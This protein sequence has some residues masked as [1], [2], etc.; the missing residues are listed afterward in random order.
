MSSKPCVFLLP[1]LMCDEA[2]WQQ[3]AQALAP[4]ADIRIPVFRGYY[5]LQAMAEFVL[6]QAPEKFSLAGHSMGGRVAWEVMALAG[7]RIERL[8]VLD[9]GMHGVKPGEGDKR[10]VLLKAANEQGLQAVA[11]AWILPMLHPARHTDQKL[12]A[13]IT[14]MIMRNS[15]KD[16]AGQVQALLG[17]D[18]RSSLLSTI[19]Q[20]VWLVV[21][22]EDGWSPVSQHQQMQSLLQRSELRTVA[23]AGHMSTMEQPEAVSKILLEWLHESL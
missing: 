22:D 17:R 13:E 23:Q 3:Q 20:K 12:I 14:A 19:K 8:A 21:G 15:V 9:S 2:I 18:E 10:A 11:D 16:F 6:Q 7:K 1:G 5:S 4:Y